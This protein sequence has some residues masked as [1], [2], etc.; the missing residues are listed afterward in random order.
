MN[1]YN[2]LQESWQA[3]DNVEV[4]AI[5]TE[6][7]I[8]W[9]KEPVTI[10]ISRP[11]RL[12]RARALGY[13]AKQGILIVRQRVN[14]GGKDRPHEL[15]GRKPKHRRLNMVHDK[16]YQ[17]IS[18]E[19]A[20]LKYP[21]CE[22]LNS[23]FVGKDGIHAWYEVILIDKTHPSIKADPKLNWVLNPANRGRVHRGLTSAA[24]KSRGLR[25]KGLGAEKVRPSKQS[26]VR[27]WD[28]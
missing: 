22:V 25:R 13:K 16:N 5:W 6:R 11:T 14:R 10:R 20:N 27:V 23:Y 24:R 2:K 3:K 9:R 28:Y 21:N 1:L 12:D 17:H 4:D 7:L 8:A 26:K 18:E 19:R 15:G